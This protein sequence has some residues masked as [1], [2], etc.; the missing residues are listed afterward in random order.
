MTAMALKKNNMKKGPF[1][2]KGYSYPGT[3]PAKN[4]DNE[5]VQDST[6]QQGYQITGSGIQTF[7]SVE[8]LKAA[9][10]AALGAVGVS[11]AVKN[12]K[13]TLESEY[14]KEDKKE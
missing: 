6:K 1:K 12:I 9:G 11:A 14:G 3:S 10:V 4:K 5:L 13:N 7:K 8:R 2:M